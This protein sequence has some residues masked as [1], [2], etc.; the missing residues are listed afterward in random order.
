MPAA[1]GAGG[2]PGAQFGCVGELRDQLEVGLLLD[3]AGHSHAQQRVV[4]DEDEVQGCRHGR[5]A[6]PV[7]D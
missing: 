1:A 2:E 4:V 7:L 3:V 6:I 5:S